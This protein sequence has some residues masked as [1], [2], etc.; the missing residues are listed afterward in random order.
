M[1]ANRYEIIPMEFLGT[2]TGNF[3]V[4]EIDSESKYGYTVA[5]FVDSREAAEAL[6]EQFTAEVPEGFE[7][8]SLGLNSPY[9]LINRASRVQVWYGAMFARFY[10]GIPAH[11]KNSGVKALSTP[12]APLGFDT[13]AEAVAYAR[14]LIPAATAKHDRVHAAAL[15]LNAPRQ[16]VKVS[17]RINAWKASD[18]R[19]IVKTARKRLGRNGYRA[20]GF[21]LLASV[22]GPEIGF[23]AKLSEAKNAK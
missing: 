1:I 2:L 15:R 12:E 23:F 22:N 13:L 21:E 8:T 14:T 5:A 18:G 10:V 3:E 19:V 17:P 6:V 11:P 20:A 4:R 9:N 7:Q 16:W